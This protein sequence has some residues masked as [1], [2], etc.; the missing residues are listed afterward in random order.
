MY[1]LPSWE[2]HWPRD[3]PTAGGGG[4]GRGGIV[5]LAGFVFQLSSVVFTAFLLVLGLWLAYDASVTARE[6]LAFAVPLLFGVVCG[7]GACAP[8]ES[9]SFNSRSAADRGR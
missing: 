2:R 1:R 4:P 3:G 7:Y 8:G 9:C 6:I 5:F